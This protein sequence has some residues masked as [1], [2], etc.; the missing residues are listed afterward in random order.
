[1]SNA[2]GKVSNA[3]GDSIRD[4]LVAAIPNLRAFAVSLCG[5]PHLANDLVQE[6]L[7]KAWANQNSFELG[8]NL[9]AWLFRI[10]RNTYFSDYRKSRRQVQDEDGAAA[11]Q[12]TSLPQQEGYAELQ[13]FKRM[14]KHLSADQREALLLIGA[15]GVSYEEAAAITGCAVGTVKSRVNRARIRLVELMGLDADAG[16]KI[17]QEAAIGGKAPGKSSAG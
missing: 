14:L 13:D 7:M 11:E 10:L 9:K 6:T 5:D 8:T 15:E 3:Q 2:Q 1:M 4:A 12:L 17:T 16:A